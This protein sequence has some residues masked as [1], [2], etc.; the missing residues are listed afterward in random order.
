MSLKNKIL[1]IL[2]FIVI[3]GVA[4]AFLFP[5]L[6]AAFV[7][8]ALA[9][10]GISF[11]VKD[12]EAQRQR[13]K[14]N[15]QIG[16]YQRGE[17]IAEEVRKRLR[18]DQIT[19]ANR[20]SEIEHRELNLED[21]LKQTQSVTELAKQAYQEA[22]ENHEKPTEPNPSRRLRRDYLRDVREQLHESTGTGE[23]GK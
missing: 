16:R 14:I 6:W 17:E 20:A 19:H 1:A 13:D 5:D 8:I 7:G 11:G 18:E 9:A 4:L 2:F 12:D 23:R 21:E 10:L 22:L 3:V 15:Q